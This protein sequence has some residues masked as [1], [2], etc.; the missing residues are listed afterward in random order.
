MYFV[1][2]GTVMVVVVVVVVVVVAMG[3]ARRIL[4]DMSILRDTVVATTAW[5]RRKMMVD[6]LDCSLATGD[7]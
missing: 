4:Y 5:G 6:S 3:P 1:V 2:V 7:N